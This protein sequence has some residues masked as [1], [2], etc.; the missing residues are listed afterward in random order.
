MKRMAKEYIEKEKF[1]HLFR[2]TKDTYL[3]DDHKK[4][5]EILEQEAMAKEYIERERVIHELVCNSVIYF[6][7]T[8]VLASIIGKINL[9]PTADV[10]EVKHGHWILLDECANEGVY[11]PVCSKKVY[12][13]DYANQNLKSNFCPNCGAKMDGERKE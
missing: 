12:R 2:G 11:C 5:I 4:V 7:D 8:K 13:K 1:K 3:D 6:V 10:V 9:I